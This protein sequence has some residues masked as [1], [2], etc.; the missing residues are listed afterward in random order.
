MPTILKCVSS[1]QGHELLIIPRRLSVLSYDGAHEI[2]GWRSRWRCAVSSIALRAGKERPPKPSPQTSPCCIYYTCVSVSAVC[3][4]PVLTCAL[5]R[6]IALPPERQ[7]Y[8]V[9]A[10]A[11]DRVSTGSSEKRAPRHTRGVQSEDW[12]RQPGVAWTVG[13]AAA[14]LC[15]ICDHRNCTSLG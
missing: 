5:P 12:T 14:D 8:P 3:V 7:R 2:I 4:L 6:N 13:I 15:A 9:V 11:S 1:Y 10:A